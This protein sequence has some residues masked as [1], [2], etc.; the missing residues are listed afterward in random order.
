ML[1]ITGGRGVSSE[2]EGMDHWTLV[3]GEVVMGCLSNYFFLFCREK[4]GST[5]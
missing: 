2:E 1:V 3:G 5:G 4:L